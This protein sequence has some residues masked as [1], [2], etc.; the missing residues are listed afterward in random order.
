MTKVRTKLIDEQSLNV[1]NN[2]DVAIYI[3]WQVSL[4]HPLVIEDLLSTESQSGV[5]F[6]YLINKVKDT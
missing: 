6:Q 5:P 1:N 2:D 3:K 4:S